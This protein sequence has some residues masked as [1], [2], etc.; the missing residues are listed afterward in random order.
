MV[1]G[2]GWSQLDLYRTQRSSP[3][4]SNKWY[5]P[6]S[7]LSHG[8]CVN[9]SQT[10]VPILEESLSQIF[11]HSKWKKCIGHLTDYSTLRLRVA[12]RY[13]IHLRIV[14]SVQQQLCVPLQHTC[15][16]SCS[17]SDLLASHSSELLSAV[18]SFSVVVFLTMMIWLALLCDH[19]RYASISLAY[20]DYLRL[21]LGLSVSQSKPLEAII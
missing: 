2:R 21:F 12:C 9:D 4:L 8:S 14:S 16:S 17:L 3:V 13:L 7:W 15:C 20:L 10:P 5:M 11:Q 1:R 18:P 6:S 19:T